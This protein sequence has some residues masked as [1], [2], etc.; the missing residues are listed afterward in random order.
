LVGTVFPD[1][2]EVGARCLVQNFGEERNDVAA[3]GVLGVA[4]RAFERRLNGDYA[5]IVVNLL[6]LE[7]CVPANFA[8][9]SAQMVKGVESTV[10]FGILQQ[11]ISTNEL[12]VL[13]CKQTT[14][15]LK[16]SGRTSG[17]QV[18]HPSIPTR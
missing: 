4:D 6:V 8:P 5:V 3:D 14:A 10:S 12:T 18:N 17:S 1:E 7:G 15:F 9:S 11:W 16:V 13:A 2:D